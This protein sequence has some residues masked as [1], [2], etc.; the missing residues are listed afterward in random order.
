VNIQ[1]ACKTGKVISRPCF[2]S[3]YGWDTFVGLPHLCVDPEWTIQDLRADDWFVKETMIS[4]EGF[5]RKAAE[6]LKEV[7]TKGGFEMIRYTGQDPQ[8]GWECE[9]ISKL[10]EK[11][12][13]GQPN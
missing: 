11:L 12:F 4:Q 2:K 9:V 7:E 3:S 8:P 1:D 6:A 10:A 5:W 13:G